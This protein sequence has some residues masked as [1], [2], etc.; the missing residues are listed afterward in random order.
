M[1]EAH[2]EGEATGGT[3]PTDCVGAKQAMQMLGVR[4]QTL[5]AYVSRGWIRSIRQPGRRDRL[6]LREDIERMGSRSLARAGHGPVAASAM[7]HGEP[8]IPTSITE[9]TPH[10]PRYRGHLAV[11]LAR[12]RVP[13][14][15]V[16]ELLWSGALPETPVRWPVGRPS[17]ELKRLL[18]SLGTAQVS[19]RLIEIFAIVT[20]HL[21]LGRGTV[22]ERVQGGQ[23]LQAAQQ[24]IT[25]LVGC[26]GL[27]MPQPRHAPMRSGQTVAEG[28]M[29]ALGVTPSD[30]HHE[31]V[32]T[33][34][35][36]LADNELSPG[37]FAVRIGASSGGTLHSCI[38]AGL[39]AS[40]GLQVAR[41]FDRVD[42]FLHGAT[43]KAALLKRAAALQ[44]RGTAVPGF[45]HPLYPRGDARAQLLLEFVAARRPHSRELDAVHGFAEEMQRVTG[46][47]PRH[48]LPMVALARAMGMPRQTPSALFVLGRIAGWVAHA[49][50]QRQSGQMLRPRAK[51]V[52]EPA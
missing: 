21:G 20:L 1:D 47:P 28:L 50:E 11:D 12:R 8:I 15:S 51:F 25:T 44:A 24:I 27:A 22:A 30:E 26:M 18:S 7:H 29:H 9:I 42:E 40:S 19:D 48:E 13:F 46:L 45:V 38:A 37:T 16:A 34:L 41:V 31:A 23:T 52:G 14:E 6:Y 4:A 35:T 49:Q 10:G 17:N 33:M 43:S 5:Y 32:E 2:S 39:C 3:R 36:L